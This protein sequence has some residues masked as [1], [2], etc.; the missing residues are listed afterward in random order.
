MISIGI[1]P[2]HQTEAGSPVSVSQPMTL[3]SSVRMTLTSG[4]GLELGGNLLE[5]EEDNAG[6]AE[7]ERGSGGLAG[8]FKEQG[9]ELV[10]VGVR[11]RNA[12]K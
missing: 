2:I 5:E 1:T 6:D 3:M 9:E 12:V 11:A 8:C 4:G 10:Q 7:D